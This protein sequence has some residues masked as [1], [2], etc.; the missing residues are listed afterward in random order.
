[1]SERM[2]VFSI[3]IGSALGII[4]GVINALFFHNLAI[5]IWTISNFF[6]LVWAIG[7]KY[8]WWNTAMSYDAMIAMYGTYTA[9]NV[10][11][12]GMM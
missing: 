12:M 3:V 2:G 10:Y 5:A 11:A 9:C 1:M 4:G 8:K 7:G 6:L